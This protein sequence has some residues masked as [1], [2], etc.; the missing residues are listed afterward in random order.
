M[1][2]VKKIQLLSAMVAHQFTKIPLI[3]ACPYFFTFLRVWIIWFD[4][5]LFWFTFFK[6]FLKLFIG[7]WYPLWKVCFSIHIL[8]YLH[9]NRC[10]W[11][12]QFLWRWVAYKIPVFL[13]LRPAFWRKSNIFNTFASLSINFVQLQFMLFSLFL[14]VNTKLVFWFVFSFLYLFIFIGSKLRINW[15]QNYWRFGIDW[16]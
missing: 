5:L 11:L 13:C 16:L 10:L 8:W 4:R 14:E 7:C 3:I 9:R 6:L 2:E 1:T 12:G 15:R